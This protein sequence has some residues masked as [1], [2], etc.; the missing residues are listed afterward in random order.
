M[1]VPF[2]RILVKPIDTEKTTES[3]LIMHVDQNTSAVVSSEVLFVGEKTESSVKVGDIVYFLARTG[4]K[5]KTEDSEYLLLDE[6]DI[7]AIQ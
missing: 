3:G 2:D 6:K 7:I 4:R 5:F 1:K